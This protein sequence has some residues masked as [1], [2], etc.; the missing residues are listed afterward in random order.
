MKEFIKRI[1]VLGGV[2]K[3]IYWKL[4]AQKSNPTPFPGSAEYWEKRYA[5]GRNSGVGSYAQ[6]A[7]F[8][9]EVLNRFVATHHV[10][11]V[12]EF[13][14]GDGNQL[15][16]AKYPKYIGFDVS[17]TAISKCRGRF[18]QD[19]GKAFCL[20]SEYANQTAELAL[21]LDTIYHLVEDDVF[22]RYMRTLFAAATRYVII[23]SSDSDDDEGYEVS[24]HVRH[25]KFNRWIQH[26][27]P[28]WKLVEHLPNRYP[29]R[30]DF[31]T[32]SFAD[33]FIYEETGNSAAIDRS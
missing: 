15:S 20:M 24:H 7:E 5:A 27:L 31:R 8:K 17:A 25:R 26:N 6:F 18:D 30:G 13:G 28:N 9:A 33:F 11:S 4:V 21:S 29:Y 14:C 23:Y 12:I 19:V 3:R 1:P 32:G 10:R 2:A 22:N 16:L